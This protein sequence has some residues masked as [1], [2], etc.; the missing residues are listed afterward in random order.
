[1]P[2]PP[3]AQ[4]CAVSIHLHIVDSAADRRR[5]VALARTFRG[6]S[7]VWCPQLDSEVLG[8][9]HPTKN[10]LWQRA[11]SQLW[12]ARDER[13]R[14]VGRVSASWDPRHA[15]S[16]G[17]AASWFGFFDADGPA[18][19]RLLLDAAWTWS[20]EQGAQTMLGPADPDTNHE[21]GCLIEGF[22]K[23]PYLMMPHNPP[24][25]GEWL[26]GA[27]LE[28]AKDL[29]AFE[30]GS[31]VF[32]PILD[33]LR[34]IVD[35]ILE[36]TGLRI[37]PIT[38]QDFAHQLELIHRVYQGAWRD[39]WGFLPT[40]L[41]EFRFEAE[42]MKFL[43]DSRIAFLALR[44]E[45]PVGVLL[46]MP[47]A[48]QALR[49]IQAKLFPFGLFRLPF[50]LRKINRCRTVLLGVLPKFRQR[51]IDVAL[52]YHMAKGCVEAG[53]QHAELS[54]VLEDNVAMTRLADAYGGKVRTRYRIYRRKD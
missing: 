39:N 40:T 23:L 14:P 25:Y 10:P 38:K 20:R 24:S 32:P 47:D 21:C 28:K 48:N 41:E 54:W 45:E 43:L 19:T 2:W 12:I 3:P 13:G 37:V 4:T 8:L 36:R 52:V 17:E 5:F 34:P 42:A 1:M 16:L 51:G 26:E 30:S 15:E 9:L 53:Y 7:N 27:G 11:C 31:E 33:R 46:G 18:T 35:R 44:G 29:L 22:D 50:L 49:P 6:S